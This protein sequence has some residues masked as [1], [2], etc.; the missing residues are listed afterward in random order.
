MFD[1]KKSRVEDGKRIEPQATSQTF[2][3]QN[4]NISDANLILEAWQRKRGDDEL[5][6]VFVDCTHGEQPQHFVYSFLLPPELTSREAVACAEY[7]HREANR[8]PPAGSV[9]VLRVTQEIVD[10]L[11][12][13][14]CIDPNKGLCDFCGIHEVL[15]MMYSARDFVMQNGIMSMGGW[16][17]CA[18]CSALIDDD[19]R[20]GMV[21]RVSGSL[22]VD[23]P[24]RHEIAKRQVVDFFAHRLYQ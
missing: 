19:D 16:R 21:E 3:P 15:V 4:V 22:G 13:R 17:A 8:S 10:K 14:R 11:K 5:W 20:D 23:T 12:G 1:S 18:R 9:E 2:F 7:S 24:R 6:F